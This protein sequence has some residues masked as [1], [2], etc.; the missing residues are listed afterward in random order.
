MDTRGHFDIAYR[1]AAHQHR[2]CS[3]ERGFK[4]LKTTLWRASILITLWLAALV[5]NW[6]SGPIS[7]LLGSMVRAFS[8]VL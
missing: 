1:L 2:I 5:S 8:I 7:D 6:T 4:N 3:L